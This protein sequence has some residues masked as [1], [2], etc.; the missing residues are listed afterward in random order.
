M[1][2]NH[3]KKAY[4]KGF[5]LCSSADN[6]HITTVNLSWLLR[7]QFFASLSCFWILYQRNLKRAVSNPGVQIAN[8]GLLKVFKTP[9][10]GSRGIWKCVFKRRLVATLLLGKSY[11]K[12]NRRCI[13]FFDS[14]SGWWWMMVPLRSVHNSYIIIRSYKHVIQ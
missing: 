7:V 8:C 14:Q 2:H 11:K 12:I 10:N 4:N 9:F 3:R 6:V 1:T 13:V 5:T